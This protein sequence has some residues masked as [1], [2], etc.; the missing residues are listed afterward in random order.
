MGPLLIFKFVQTAAAVVLVGV[1][2]LRMLA[3]GTGARRTLRWNWLAWGSWAILT[4][5]AEGVLVLTTASMT[6]ETCAELWECEAV[7][8]VLTGTRFG[9]V[10]LVRAGLLTGVFVLMLAMAAIRRYGRW[11]VPAVLDAANLLLATAALASQVWAGH[12]PLSAHSAWM[13][14]ADALHALAAGAWPGGLLPLAVLLMR[15]RRDADL[16]VSAATITRRFSR[17]CVAAV[18]I[19][20]FT[21]LL[22]SLGMTG[23]LSALWPWALWRSAY[24]K[25][26][27]CKVALFVGMLGLGALNHRRVNQSVVGDAVE[28]VRRMCRDVGWECALAV[29]V[30]VATEALAMSAPP[31]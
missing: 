25:L 5:A 31:Q 24:G 17:M 2:V 13:L 10:W 14:P 8:L 6:G 22:N 26:L 15:A 9:T 4:V 28:T 21:G 7:G 23:T 27:L 12:A 11:R 20:A 19:L 18:A 3:L 30:L 16:V 1:L 29:G